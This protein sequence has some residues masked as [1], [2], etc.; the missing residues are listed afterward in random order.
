ML[1]AT[2]VRQTALALALSVGA[3]LTLAACG[4]APPAAQPP[5]TTPTP[6]TVA[7]SVPSPPPPASPMSPSITPPTTPSHAPPSTSAHAPAT[8][9][10]PSTGTQAAP[11]PGGGRCHTSMLSGQVS[12]GSPGAGQRYA[13]L[14]LTNSSGQP[15]TIFGYGGLQLIGE[16]GTALPTDLERTPAP[17]PQLIHLEPGKSVSANLHWGAIPG[18]NEAATGTC[19]PEPVQALVTP[20]D[21]TDPLVVSWSMGPV[22]QQGR[23]EGSAY[24]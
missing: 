11:Q 13:T 19:Q 7:T 10:A 17:P 24:Q 12:S 16:D 1:R 18:E 2:K 8:T 22:C 9:S 15:C 21:E 6:P 23:I 14:T 5:V 4:E 3:G 20:P